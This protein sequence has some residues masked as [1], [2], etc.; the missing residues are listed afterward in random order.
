MILTFE[1]NLDMNQRVKYLCQRSFSSETVVM[2][3]T[4]TNTRSVP[5]ALLGP[6]KWSVKIF[7]QN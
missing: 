2:T 3:H 5:T 1:L 6:L 4:D 7:P